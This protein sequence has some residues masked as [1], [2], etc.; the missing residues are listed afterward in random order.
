MRLATPRTAA[1]LALLAL[2]A[3]VTAADSRQPA[4]AAGQPAADR[5]FITIEDE[6]RQLVADLASLKPPPGQQPPHAYFTLTPLYNAGVPDDELEATRLAFFKLLNSLSW[7]PDIIL[8]TAVNPQKTLYR[9][10]LKALPLT[11]LHLQGHPYSVAIRLPENRDYLR[12]LAFRMDWFLAVASRPPAYDALAHIPKKAV[13][14][15]QKLKVEAADNIRDATLIRAGFKESG[16]SPHNRLIERHEGAGGYYWKS[17]NFAGGEGRKNLFAHPLGPAADANAFQHD[18]GAIIFRLPNGLHGYMLTDGQGNH[19]SQAPTGVLRDPKQPDAPVRSATSCMACHGGGLIDKVDEIRALAEAADSPLPRAVAKKVLLLH[20]AREKF[21]A[22][23][24]ADTA[25]YRAALAKLGVKPDGPEPVSAAARRY[26]ED[27]DLRRAAAE[28]WLPADQFQAKLNAIP[29]IFTTRTGMAS[30]R[31]PNGK[32][33]R[34]ALVD[35]YGMLL[36]QARP[37]ITYHAPIGPVE[38]TRYWGPTVPTQSA[39]PFRMG[40]RAVTAYK[41]RPVIDP[42]FRV[43]AAVTEDGS[44]VQL[45]D[46]PTNELRHTLPAQGR[47]LGVAFSADGKLLAS[48]GTDGVIIFTDAQT[49]K[50][51][52]RTPAP[53]DPQ[54]KK[55]QGRAA[56]AFSPDGRELVA[57]PERPTAYTKT[58][59]FYD[60][61]TGR[62]TRSVGQNFNR[63]RTLAYSPDGTSLLLDGALY[64]KI[65]ALKEDDR[66]RLL[67]ARDE[68]GSTAH[69]FSADGKYLC[70]T[71]PSS[72]IRVFDLAKFAPVA[73]EWVMFEGGP[74]SAGACAGQAAAFSPDGG[75]LVVA[76]K[77]GYL[78]VWAVPTLKLVRAVRCQPDEPHTLQFMPD[79]RRLAACGDDGAIR[80]WDW[81]ALSKAA[82]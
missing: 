33:K 76:H 65:A 5:P 61:K 11:L 52:A 62:H 59:E 51:I 53:H 1:A 71:Y 72:A 13:E 3:A 69:A 46:L 54:N 70:M 6:A 80:F 77:G 81:A 38:P 36:R 49:G 45:F 40:A 14:L 28:L 12:S 34:G 58:L 37:D 57:T 42:T 10:D 27:V 78:T 31:E 17:Y 24:K 4:A 44:R 41:T 48:S 55:D 64:V 26:E 2:L 67:G 20:P 23:I 50:E 47:V 68:S 15:E 39:D 29:A 9:V 82:D 43:V 18:V 73:E 7:Q 66:P 19:L 35:A 21:A 75:H 22:A 79:G 25:D 60:P 32:V 8:P 30:L 74:P 63:A 56:L 16:V